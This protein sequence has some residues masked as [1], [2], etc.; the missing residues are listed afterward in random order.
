M[1][2]VMF[3][4]FNFNLELIFPDKSKLKLKEENITFFNII[5]ILL[6]MTCLCALCVV[7][8]FKPLGP[9]IL[10]KSKRD[11]DYINFKC[12]MNGD[13][14]VRDFIRVYCKEEK[15]KQARDLPTEDYPHF[16]FHLYPPVVIQNLLPFEI[17]IDSMVCMIRDPHATT[18]QINFYVSGFWLC[19]SY[20][21]IR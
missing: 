10:W 18:L 1:K 16:V 8:S 4:F 12:V 2:K 11:S 17:F 14:S 19:S 21:Q 20:D 9:P 6:T 13:D 3:S 15:Y 7:S 5:M